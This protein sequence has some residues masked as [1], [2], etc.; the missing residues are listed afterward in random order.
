MFICGNIIYMNLLKFVRVLLLVLIIIGVALLATQKIWVPTLVDRIIQ[1]QDKELKVL[2][3]KINTQVSSVRDFSGTYSSEFGVGELEVLV[4]S[5]TKIKVVGKTVLS[6]PGNMENKEVA[7]AHTG[8][9]DAILEVDDQKGMFI[10][11][12]N[13]ECRLYFEFE[14]GGKL[15][16]TG[17]EDCNVYID[18]FTGNYYK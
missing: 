1:Y 13:N 10:D 9:I 11:P 12:E 15:A 2:K 4:L 14:L 5:N 6:G 7:E 18:N 16:I 8:H 17:G 3:P